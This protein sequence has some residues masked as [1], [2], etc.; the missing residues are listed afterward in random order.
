MANRM[1]HTTFGLTYDVD[2]QTAK[3]QP[4]NAYHPGNYSTNATTG[5]DSNLNRQ[6]TFNDCGVVEQTDATDHHHGN[7]PIPDSE[8]YHLTN[9]H[10]QQHNHHN[11]QWQGNPGGY[12]HDDEQAQVPPPHLHHFHYH[13]PQYSNFYTGR[14]QNDR[15]I[16]GREREEAEGGN[17]VMFAD[18]QGQVQWSQ[19]HTHNVGYGQTEVK[20]S[21][22]VQPSHNPAYSHDRG[23]YEMKGGNMVPPLQSTAY[24]HE[25]GEYEIKGGNSAIPSHTVA[26]SYDRE[27]ETPRSEEN[28]VPPLQMHNMHGYTDDGYQRLLHT[29]SYPTDTS[30]QQNHPS[31]HA[32]LPTSHFVSSDPV[33]AM[34]G[35]NSNTQPEYQ[36]NY[37][38]QYRHTKTGGV[39]SNTN[40]EKEMANIRGQQRR[41]DSQKEF[42]SQGLRSE[43]IHI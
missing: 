34:A 32:S 2:N 9:E 41:E 30:N 1:Q 43:L 11:D 5:S 18:T 15:L 6:Q 23:E 27:Y 24:S 13:D 19:G 35:S 37:K 21:N 3:S 29:D 40:S 38:V 26:Y 25:R 22:S 39:E 8:I 31:S 7:Q 16:E 36:E 20:G 14:L 17:D 33:P 10:L 28:Y 4:S 12:G 42:V